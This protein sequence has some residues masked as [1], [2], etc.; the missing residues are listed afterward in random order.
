MENKK[1]LRKSVLFVKIRVLY[2][3]VYVTS[4]SSFLDR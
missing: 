1:N 3:H 4:Y 2:C